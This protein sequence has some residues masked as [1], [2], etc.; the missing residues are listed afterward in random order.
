M[1]KRHHS[2]KLECLALKGAVCNQL[3]DYL[4]YALK[5][6]VYTDNNPLL[7]VLLSE[8]L[9]ATGQWWV[10]ELADFNLQMHYK[11]G[12]RHQDAN[13][14]SLFSENIHQYTSGVEQS[15]INAI[16]EGVHSTKK[17]RFG[18]VQLIQVKLTQKC[19]HLHLIR[20]AYRKLTSTM[21]RIKIF[22]SRK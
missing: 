5:V 18:S 17:K 2:S 8:K 9:S 7:Y 11:P 13:A 22:A 3:R 20:T 12:R 1:E 14:L 10:N 16:F 19:I 4:L 15:S 21:N 6:E